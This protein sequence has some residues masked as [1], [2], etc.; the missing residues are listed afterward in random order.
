MISPEVSCNQDLRVRHNDL[1]NYEIT[2]YG[3]R[4]AVAGF[5]GP[6]VYEYVPFYVQLSWLF[7]LST[8]LTIA[9]KK[10]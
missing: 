10:N 3:V 4:K 7:S 1:I 6:V 2:S 9:A 5:A 8:K